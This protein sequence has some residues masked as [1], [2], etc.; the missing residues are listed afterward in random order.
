MHLAAAELTITHIVRQE[1]VSDS[2]APLIEILRTL[3]VETSYSIHLNHPK[4]LKAWPKLRSHNRTK[5][6]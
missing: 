6:F 3:T 4:M 1:I 2:V 5:A